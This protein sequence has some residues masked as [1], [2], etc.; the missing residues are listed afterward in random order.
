KARRVREELSYQVPGSTVEHFDVR[1]AP[2][3][4]AGDDVGLTVLVHVPGGHENTAGEV[5]PVREKAADQVTG[6]AVIHL[7]VRSAPGASRGDNILYPVACN[8]RGCNAH[9]AGEAGPKRKEAVLERPIGG[10]EHLDVRP[11]ARSRC[12]CIELRR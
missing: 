1:P 2:G 3:V 10:I 4:G 8:I 9:A 5:R 12:D 11:T 7:D 6:R